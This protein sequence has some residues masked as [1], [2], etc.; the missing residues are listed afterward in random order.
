MKQNVDS[1]ENPEITMDENKRAVGKWE[2]TKHLGLIA[3]IPEIV[4]MNRIT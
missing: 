4:M 1:E 2:A 3:A